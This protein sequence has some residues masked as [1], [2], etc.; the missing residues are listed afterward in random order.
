[1]P[2]PVDSS[3]FGQIPVESGVRWNVFVRLDKIKI[4][5]IPD[6]P[7]E[8][9]RLCIAMQK[10]KSAMQN[11]L[12]SVPWIAL[13]FLRSMRNR[14]FLARKYSILVLQYNTPVSE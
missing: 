12:E 7:L 10:E 4:Q 2:I 13:R 14:I 9:I 3:G 8:S 5:W 11:T 6:S 1:M